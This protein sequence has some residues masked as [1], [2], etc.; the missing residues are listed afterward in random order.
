MLIFS[1]KCDV[2]LNLL[3]EVCIVN[4][5]EKIYKYTDFCLRVSG[6]RY[7]DQN[8]WVVTHRNVQCFLFS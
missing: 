8:V 5:I 3:G 7:M 1:L 2:L 6:F 4:Q